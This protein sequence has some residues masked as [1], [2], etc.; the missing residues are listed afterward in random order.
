MVKAAKTHKRLPLGI[1]TNQPELDFMCAAKC[2]HPIF[3]YGKLKYNQPFYPT[4]QRSKTSHNIIGN[5]DEVTEMILETIKKGL[6]MMRA[7]LF[8]TEINLICRS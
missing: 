4:L 3:P 2:R 6:F 8:D 7:I 1:N 5:N